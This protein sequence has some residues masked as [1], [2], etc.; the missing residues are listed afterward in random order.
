MKA[1]KAVS[2]IELM[3]AM[4]VMIVL[5]TLAIGIYSMSIRVFTAET[6]RS[7]LRQNMFAAMQVMSDRLR[8]ARSITAATNRSITFWA[9]L[10][11]SETQEAGEAIIFSWSG[12][13]GQPLIMSVDGSQKR[14]LESVYNFALTYDSAVVTSIRQV[15]ITLRATQGA[16]SITISTSVKPRNL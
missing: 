16:E 8:D 1:R 14:I 5:V 4:V 6:N 3:I 15:N 10:N 9:D 12:T 13:G 2:L 11:Y 7:N